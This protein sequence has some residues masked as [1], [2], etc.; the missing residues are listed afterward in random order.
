MDMGKAFTLLKDDEGEVKHKGR[1]VPYRDS[2]GFLTIGY[3]TLIDPERGGGLSDEE[4]AY[5]LMNRLQEAA[6][7]LKAALPFW[8]RLNEARQIALASMVYQMGI[9]RF[10]TFK[11]MIRALEIGHYDRAYTEALDSLWAKQTYK[12]ALRIAQMIKAG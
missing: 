8:G 1:H 9:G 7:E 5:L 3:G 12:R 4:A 2:R 6:D 11:K 10:L